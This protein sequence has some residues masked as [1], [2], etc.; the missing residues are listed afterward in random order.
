MAEHNWSEARVARLRELHAEG[1]SSTHIAAALGGITRN[2]VI[3]KLHRMGD[4][5]QHASAR[6]SSEAP[7][8]T[9]VGSGEQAQP[10]GAI[11]AGAERR[12]DEGVRIA[13]RQ[14][15]APVP[16]MLL[17]DALGTGSCRYP[18]GTPGHEDFGFCGHPSEP[19]RVY[20]AYHDAVCH[21]RMTRRAAEALAHQRSSLRAET[22]E[23]SA[24]GRQTLAGGL[25]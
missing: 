13:P 9:A 25:L 21:V 22:K 10:S 18:I 23:I 20:C 14:L 17:L 16:K 6:H 3:G 5:A 24:T 15:E 19:G 11:A 4:S 1:W 7:R 2:A 12:A 8:E